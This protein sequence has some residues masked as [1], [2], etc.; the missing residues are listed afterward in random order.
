M[1]PLHGDPCQS[2]ALPRPAACRCPLQRRSLAQLGS[3]RLSVTAAG[4]AR[5][6]GEGGGVWCA[7]VWP[8]FCPLERLG[9][10]G[11]PN[12]A[13]LGSNTPY[14]PLPFPFPLFTRPGGQATLPRAEMG[15]L[16][17]AESLDA[18]RS[19]LNSKH[20]AAHREDD[21]RDPPPSRAR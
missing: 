15:S 8:L 20:G 18:G 16:S 2:A 17:R 7:A 10:F 6:G 9:A 3:H 4:A 19:H 21:R 5:A 14:T 13:V 12:P 1:Q 11:G